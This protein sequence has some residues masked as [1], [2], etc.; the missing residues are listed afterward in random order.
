M[1]LPVESNGGFSVTKVGLPRLGE[2]VRSGV[3]GTLQ[4]N[5]GSFN[6]N[7]KREWDQLR[8]FDVLFLVTIDM[9]QAMTEAEAEANSGEEKIKVNDEDDL[10][11]A[12]RYGITAVRGCEIIDVRDDQGN[13]VNPPGNL[14]SKARGNRRS[15]RV[16][17]DPAQYHFDEKSKRNRAR[18]LKVYEEIN[19]VV[20]R[21][22]KENNFKSV[23]ETIRDLMKGE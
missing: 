2:V 19:L 20:R 5:L 22:A 18:G 15:I 4:L 23:L 9:S 12:R 6:D 7:V 10:T 8:E 11:F 1:A 16:S 14:P 13:E 21:G 3:E 17:L